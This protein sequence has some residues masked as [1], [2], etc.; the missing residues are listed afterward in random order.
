MTASETESIA[1][2]A[3]A[4]ERDG[5]AIVRDAL[6]ADLVS[7]LWDAVESVKDGPGVRSR[8][9]IY[10]IRNLLSLAPEVK[11]A[12]DA[13]VIKSLLESSLGPEGFLV[14]GLF[15][16]K[17]PE[18]MWKVPWH[19]DATITVRE[20]A[21]TTGF[22]PWSVKAGV[23]HVQAPPY[24]L[25]TLLSLRLHLDGCEEEQGALRVIP[26]S[27]NFGRLPTDSIPQFT[28]V[29]S[30]ICAVPQGGL[31]AM[32]PL[33]LHASSATPTV[34]R[35]HVIHLYFAASSLPAPLEWYEAHRITP[36]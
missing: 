2:Y 4:I 24:V 33:L 36:S 31:L 30:E 5:F 22:G 26:G 28:R 8:N 13:P 3:G 17:R 11:R 25:Y 27:H 15:F 7:E 34:H 20:T 14:G 9:G 29:A 19:Q 6:D 21:E 1:S 12:L 10:A 16:D 18:A 32:K 23:H 35:R